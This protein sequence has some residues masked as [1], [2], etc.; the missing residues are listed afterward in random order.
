[1]AT[2]VGPTQAAAPGIHG[3]PTNSC[4]GGIELPSRNSRTRYARVRFA[5]GGSHQP[6]DGA[7]V[8]RLPQQFGTG[9]SATSPVTQVLSSTPGCGAQPPSAR[10]A[11]ASQFNPLPAACLPRQPTAPDGI[12]GRLGPGPAPVVRPT[13]VRILLVMRVSIDIGISAGQLKSR[14]SL[15]RSAAAAAAIAYQCDTGASHIEPV[16]D[17]PL[18]LLFWRR[19]SGTVRPG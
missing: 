16:S 18:P 11:V 3:Q 7:G 17:F 8:A 12:H 1:M 13:A 9:S 14:A 5:P 6:P 4:S 19:L 15:A 10:W 2:E